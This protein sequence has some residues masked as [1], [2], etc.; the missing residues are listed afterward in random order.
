MIFYEGH[1][2]I[3]SE[4]PGLDLAGSAFMFV[5][6]VFG[7]NGLRTRKFGKNLP[8]EPGGGFGH[9][10]AQRSRPAGGGRV[11]F[12]LGFGRGPEDASHQG[13]IHPHRCLQPYAGRFT[14][15]RCPTPAIG[16]LQ[17]SEVAGPLEYKT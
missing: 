6:I 2:P 10:D 7:F 12:L 17:H 8:L 14:F 1:F 9:R 4:L 16:S 13:E 15:Y 3:G 5:D 11:Y